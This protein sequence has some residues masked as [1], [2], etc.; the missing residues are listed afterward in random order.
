MSRKIRIFWSPDVEARFNAAY[1][2]VLKLWPVPY[3]ELYVSTRFGDTHVIAS[4]PEKAPPLVLLHPAG[5]GATIWY[6]NVE[7]FSRRYRTYAVDV[8][9]DI[10]RSVLTHPIRG[11]QD[12]A[13]WIE[14]L[15]DGL[16]V[17]STYMV[18]NSYGGYLT[19]NTV[20]HLPERVTKAVLISP[21]ATFVQ[22]WPIYWHTI[23][24]GHWIAPIIRS[25]R[26]VWKA[27][28]WVWQGFPVDE[29]VARLRRIA[30]VAGYPRYRPTHNP[31]PTVFSDEELREIFTPVLLLIGDHEVIYKLERVIERATRLVSGLKAEIVPNANHVAEYTAPE[32]VNEKVLEFFHDCPPEEQEASREAVLSA[33]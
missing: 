27:N 21:A 12:F 11:R 20:L 9:G 10:N 25:K 16:H 17:E 7:A 18:G 3:E 22:I 15:F 5:G 31:P 6:R 28:S 2:A 23:I 4:G 13:D 32:A 19:F 8:I 33:T 30:Q 14:E 26:L 1:E 24:P 29:R